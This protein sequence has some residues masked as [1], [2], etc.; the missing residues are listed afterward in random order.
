MNVLIS[1]SILFYFKRYDGL[2]NSHSF[3]EFIN[4]NFINLF[5]FMAF[6]SFIL[7]DNDYY[8]IYNI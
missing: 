6:K 8:N 4:L 7:P 3:V 5:V 2:K 1:S